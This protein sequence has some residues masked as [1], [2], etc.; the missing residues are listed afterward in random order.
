MALLLAVAIIAGGYLWYARSQEL[1]CIA[2]R[3]GKPSV[4]RG[5]VPPGLLGSFAD[6]V[7]DVQDGTIRA[8]KAANGARL[9]FS[10]DIGEHT[11][12][13]LRNIFGLYPIAQLTAPRLDGRQAVHDAFTLSWLISLFRQF[14]R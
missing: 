6:A 8:Q 7:R 10:G 9:R 14:F 5:Y 3:R 12:Q 11:G 1:F 2:V 4:L 13:R